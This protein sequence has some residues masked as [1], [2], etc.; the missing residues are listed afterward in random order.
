MREQLVPLKRP[1]RA[2][3]FDG[4]QCWKRNGD[5]RASEGNQRIEKRQIILTAARS[6]ARLTRETCRPRVP[7]LE[8]CRSRH[9]DSTTACR[10]RNERVEAT[11]RDGG[12]SSA[13]GRRR[14]GAVRRRGYSSGPTVHRRTHASAQLTQAARIGG[15]V[16]TWSRPPSFVRP[17]T[18]STNRSLAMTAGES[19]KGY[20]SQS[21]RP[22]F[23]LFSM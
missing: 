14:T 10:T 20:A 21:P 17:T 12:N 16:P 11:V 8:S 1:Y 4:R 23:R 13:P 15:G 7:R 6:G 18:S 2:R 9:V 3:G 19:T 5:A 22:R